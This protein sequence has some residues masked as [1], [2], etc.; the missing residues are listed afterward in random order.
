MATISSV[1]TFEFQ[2]IKVLSLPTASLKLTCGG[3]MR[4]DKSEKFDW[5]GKRF[6]CG[7]NQVMQSLYDQLD[8]DVKRMN[9]VFK[10]KNINHECEIC[11]RRKG[12]IKVVKQNI[13]VYESI[14]AFT[15][16]TAKAPHVVVSISIEGADQHDRTSFSMTPKW[17]EETLECELFID[18]QPHEL[19]DVSRKS[20]SHM[21]PSKAV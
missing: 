7:I 2:P 16:F 21:F 10:K 3:H 19:W 17:N 12:V 1:L 5:V 15:S 4:V 6:R 8:L 11:W 18:N 9:Q 14:S 13:D 20:L